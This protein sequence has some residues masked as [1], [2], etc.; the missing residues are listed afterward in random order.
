[1]RHAGIRNS[2]CQHCPK[3]F[4]HNSE[5]REHIRTH[6]GVK[7]YICD[8]CSHAF[9]IRTNLVAHIRMHMRKKNA[10]PAPTYECYICGDG[11]KYQRK[12]YMEIHMRQHHVGG[13]IFRC[14]VCPKQFLYKN[15]LTR[16]FTVHNAV[17]KAKVTTTD[18]SSTGAK[19]DIAPIKW[20]KCD[21]CEYASKY[22]AHLKTHARTHTGDKPYKCN[23]CP[24][25]YGSTS[26]LKRHEWSN[27]SNKFIKCSECTKKFSDKSELNLHVRIVHRG[28][29]V[30]K[31]FACKICPIRTTSKSNMLKHLRIHTG[32][33]P[34]HCPHC[35]T[36]FNSKT[37][38]ER[39]A[40]DVRCST[41]FRCDICSK[42][43]QKRS[44]IESHMRLH[45]SGKL[46]GD[47]KKVTNKKRRAKALQ[48]CQCL[49]KS[50]S[51]CSLMGH[52]KRVHCISMDCLLK[53]RKIS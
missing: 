52:Y 26:H 15:E 43:F 25:A 11:V 17:H 5:L 48:C 24:K 7:P 1:M 49:F 20:Y 40:K 4:Y 47:K 44:S 9:A 45:I 18:S 27:H 37:N 33:K 2:V 50:S 31:R 8:I 29:N 32:E 46:A 28:F 6:I 36:A 38:M 22:S 30:P 16:H 19:S 10:K 21:L 23:I 39:H 35:G 13:G 3:K 14:N 51:H 41:K 53:I 34:F 42:M 12:L